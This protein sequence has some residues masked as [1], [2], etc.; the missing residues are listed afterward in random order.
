MGGPGSGLNPGDRDARPLV[1][2]CRQLRA[3]RL[4]R[5]G[6]IRP[7]ACWMG[8]WIWS[9][10][11]EEEASVFLHTYT[12]GDSGTLRLS[13]TTPDGPEGYVIPLDTTP[14]PRG[15][16]RWW[17]RCAAGPTQS[18]V[19]CG[20]RCG[21]LYLAPGSPIFSCRV[22]HG[23][24]YESSRRSGGDGELYARVGAMMGLTGSQ[25]GRLLNGR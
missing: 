8:R 9:S 24:A 2:E 25:V 14:V 10:D 6:V 7:H 3:G 4:A 5:A 17:F 12:E 18:G 1:E 21:S 22:C 15:R 11:G 19:G 23:L 16:L 20:R 13:Y